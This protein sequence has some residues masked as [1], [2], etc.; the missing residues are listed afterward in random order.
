ME[1]FAH[2]ADPE[3]DPVLLPCERPHSFF[4]DTVEAHTN[5]GTG[6]RRVLH[7]ICNL[8]RKLGAR[9]EVVEVPAVSREMEQV[10][11]TIGRAW[12]CRDVAVEMTRITFLSRRFSEL[13]S[14]GKYLC[15][16]DI[17]GSVLIA[18]WCGC[19]NSVEHIYE[20]VIRPP[21]LL[22]N[23][24]HAYTSFE[25]NC[26]GQPYLMRGTYFCQQNGVSGVCAHAT[27]RMLLNTYLGTSADKVTDPEV[28][29]ILQI[30]TEQALREMG[31]CGLTTQ[32]IGAVLSRYDKTY[33][34]MPIEEGEIDYVSFLLSLLESNSPGAIV[35][36]IEGEEANHIVPLFGHTFNSDLW[37]HEAN[38][39][40]HSIVEAGYH[41]HSNWIP[42]FI[43]HDDNFGMYYCMD[44]DS[45]TPASL[46]DK[47]AAGLSAVHAF[48]FLGEGVERTGRNAAEMTSLFLTILQQF[49]SAELGSPS[50]EDWLGRLLSACE[51]GITAPVIRPF[52]ATREQ[53]LSHL[54]QMLDWNFGSLSVADV[55]QLTVELPD[56]FWMCEV[57]VPDLYSTNKRKV[58]EVMYSVDLPED[59]KN[60]LDGFLGCRLP[61]IS[62]LVRSDGIEFQPNQLHGHVPLCPT[63]AIPPPEW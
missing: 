22:N 54:G 28:N 13:S 61:A 45:L 5:P 39:A 50:S 9:A 35:F 55:E 37:Y 4:S 30:K 31:Q 14:L 3:K 49:F 52:V 7:R 62:V 60:C 29:S 59:P 24:I 15:A 16:E 51:S 2:L 56:S 25:V 27:L 40:Y 10:R 19:D 33:Q 34:A 58:G 20:A 43:V 17:L 32:D 11:E 41:P 48:G 6:A 26:A 57:S 23:Y 38:Y 18:N 44:I 47:Y 1:P 53:Y 8:M 46:P 63:A 36:A 21:V 12:G 42:A